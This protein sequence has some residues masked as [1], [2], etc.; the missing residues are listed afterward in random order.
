LAKPITLG[1]AD[2]AKIILT[3]KDNG[4][5]KRPHQLFL[6]LQDMDSGLEAPFPLTVKDSGKGV[7]SIVSLPSRRAS[8]PLK[9]QL[10][11][12]PKTQKDIPVQLLAKSL[13]ASIVIG[14][15]GSASGLVSEVFSMQFKS[16]PNS[17]PQSHE[18]PLRYGKLPE[19]HHIFRSDPKSPPKI[20][21]LVF[22]LAV[23]ATLPALFVAVSSRSRVMPAK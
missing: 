18:V 15:F 10:T 4:K 2:V 14:S 19:I 12:F 21:S 1:S 6:L 3:A 13:R 5:A 8:C 11:S 7:V 22:V 9:F 17:P 20:V 16:D 23:G